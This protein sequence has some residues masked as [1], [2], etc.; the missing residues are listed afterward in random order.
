MMKTLS[1]VSKALEAGAVS[2]VQLT[3]SCL[4]GIAQKDGELG[5][6][7][8]VDESGAL[9]QA[10]ASDARRKEGKSWGVL[11]GVPVGI[12][13][14]IFCEGLPVTAASKILEAY[15]APYDATVIKN[16][17]GAGVII[18]GKLNQD[19]FGMGSS[20]ENSGYKI[21][22]NPLDLGRTPGGSS[23]GSAAAIKAELAFGTLGTDT[24]GSVRLPAAFTGTV[25]LKPTYGR[26]S[27]F[28]V[29]AFASSLDQVG[30]FGATVEDAAIMLQGIAGYDERD[31]TSVN[32]PVPDYR[33]ALTGGVKGLNIGI[34]KEYFIEGLDP[35]IKTCV[36][37]AVASL[38]KLG[39]TAVPI[40]LP[41][42]NLA[43][44]TY[45]IIATAE[46]SSNL[47]RYDGIR[48]GPRHG[49]EQGLR[50]LYEETRGKLFG[51]EVQRRILLGTYVLSAGYYDAYYVR[52]QKVRAMIAQDFQ[53][54]FEQVDVII[55]PTAP[56]TAYK[57]GE[58]MSDPLQMYL[59]DIFT[60]PVNLAGLPGISIPGGKSKSGLPIGVQ[61]ITKPFDEYGLLKVANALEKTLD[62]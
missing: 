57:L 59:G 14:M 12:K 8:H 30:V 55:C 26:V 60:I 18:L 23:S 34:P 39:A 20:G 51:P 25:G 15:Q 53:K 31:S 44:A 46:A 33:A 22:R 47:A 49:E 42:T 52:A 4:E 36:E 62:V 27:R 5:C 32:T 45:Y 35:E 48:Y 16:L 28:G 21:C 2:S 50:A 58:K 38:Q 40:S 11:D 43:V 24:G 13:D 37:N 10:A 29:I 7:L 19:E 56:S 41:N 61:L 6:Y 9:A 1:E 3:K 54:A 17:K